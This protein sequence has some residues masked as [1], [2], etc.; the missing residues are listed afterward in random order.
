MIQKSLVHSRDASL[1]IFELLLFIKELIISFA[2]LIFLIY[3]SVSL[4]FLF[5]IVFVLIF[6]NS[7][8]LAKKYVYNKSNYVAIVQEKFS[9]FSQLYLIA[10][11]LSKLITK[12]IFLKN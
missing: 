1:F 9:I 11:K 4:S 2:L 10:L 7:F 12:K 6:F 3:L 5:F 8:Y